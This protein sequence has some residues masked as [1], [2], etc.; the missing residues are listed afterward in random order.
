MNLSLSLH[1]QYK[2]IPSSHSKLTPAVRPDHYALLRGF[3]FYLVWVF[4]CRTALDFLLLCNKLP[5]TQGLKTP[6]IYQPT[7]LEV[8]SPITAQLDSLLRALLTGSR[9]SVGL[10]S[11]L[12]ALGNNV[13]RSSLRLL[14]VRGLKCL[15]PFCLL[16]AAPRIQKHVLSL[17]HG[18]LH[19]QSKYMGI[20]LVL[21][22]NQAK[23]TLQNLC[24]TISL[25]TAPIEMD[26][27]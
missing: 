22:L 5:H 13:I 9:L 3:L 11:F 18:F 1:S 24:N 4:F 2:H 8:R 16:R 15:F 7:V 19:L 21:N 20:F 26:K 12:D 25:S 23:A 17:P 27:E 14:V 10:H 6:P